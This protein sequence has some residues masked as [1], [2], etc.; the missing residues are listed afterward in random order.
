MK[1]VNENYYKA[2][3]TM[4]NYVRKGSI[5]KYHEHPSNE[6]GIGTLIGCAENRIQTIDVSNAEVAAKYFEPCQPP[7]RFRYK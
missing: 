5:W 1:L 3:I 7:K 2:V 4:K 6:S